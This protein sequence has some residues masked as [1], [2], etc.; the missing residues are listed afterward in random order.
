MVVAAIIVALVQ[1]L[2][3]VVGVAA[4]CVLPKNRRRC[5]T[6]ACASHV[7]QQAYV[8]KGSSKRLQIA[9]SSQ[10]P[11]KG[12]APDIHSTRHLYKLEQ[13]KQAIR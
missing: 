5:S 10:A 9:A 7:L 8:W 11:S 2:V 3:G 1:L 6:A 4:D 13:K 12:T